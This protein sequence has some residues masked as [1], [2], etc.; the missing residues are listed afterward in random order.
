VPEPRI[1]RSRRQQWRKPP[2]TVAP[3]CLAIAQIINDGI[4]NGHLSNLTVLKMGHHSKLSQ[5]EGR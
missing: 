1:C 2:A 5:S 3:T 4:A